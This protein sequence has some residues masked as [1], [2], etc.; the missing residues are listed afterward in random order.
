MTL[1]VHFPQKQGHSDGF[2]AIEL[3]VVIAILGVLAALAAPSFTESIKRYRVNSIRDNLIS[4]IQWARSE[5]IR[6]RVQVGLVQSTGCGAALGSVN[7]WD[8]GWDAFLDANGDGVFNAGE[9][10]LQT[11]TIPAGFHL[12]HDAAVASAVMRV[13]RFGQPGTASERFVITPPEGTAGAAT[14]S[15]CFFPGGSVRSKKGTPACATL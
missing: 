8:C 11:F 14:T 12:T 1:P 5:A 13:T 4:S 3:L 6:R 7:D 9:L 2:T 15:V 10:V